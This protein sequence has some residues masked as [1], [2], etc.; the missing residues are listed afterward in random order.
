[1]NLYDIA[2]A[3]ITSRLVIF[4]SMIVIRSVT[5]AAPFEDF[6][7]PSTEQSQVTESLVDDE[8]HDS[9]GCE[10]DPWVSDMTENNWN[11]SAK[12]VRRRTAKDALEEAFANT[13]D[14]IN[15]KSIQEIFPNDCDRL[16]KQVSNVVRASVTPRLIKGPDDIRRSCPRWDTLGIQDRKDFYVALVTAM[17][18]AESSCNNRIK[19]HKAKN[20]T[21]YGYWQG[22][23]PMT[24]V[25]G[26][27]WVMRQ[28]NNQV[29]KSGLLFWANSELNYWAVLN[30]E[31]HGN[32]VKQILKK[33]PA[34]VTRAANLAYKSH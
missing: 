5:V 3:K 16:I 23:R 7:Q 14:L 29:E 20:G 1:M 22:V 24:P 15:D 8:A 11:L 28:I 12:G 33:I 17:A 19:N 27:K 6:N 21:A 31:I 13:K 34:C 2:K 25:Q 10:N 4:I 26:A 18:M 9:L 32:R 30:P